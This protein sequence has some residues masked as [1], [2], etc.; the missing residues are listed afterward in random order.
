[1]FYGTTT[2]LFEDALL[3]CVQEYGTNKALFMLLQVM[4]IGSGIA[5]AF[6]YLFSKLLPQSFIACMF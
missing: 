5:W 3:L 2:L 4:C 1:M 6:F